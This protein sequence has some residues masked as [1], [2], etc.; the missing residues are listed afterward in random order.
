VQWGI[1]LQCTI[2]QTTKGKWIG[3]F[4]QEVDP[5]RNMVL[6]TIRNFL[7]MCSNVKKDLEILDDIVVYYVTQFSKKIMN[8]NVCSHVKLERWSSE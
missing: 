5:S 6:A 2:N 7:P 3:V 4:L 1:E 8:K